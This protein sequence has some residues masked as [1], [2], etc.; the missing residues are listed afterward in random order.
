MYFD[1]SGDYYDKLAE[2]YEGYMAAM[3]P[4]RK[5]QL[6][7]HGNYS[8]VLQGIYAMK[9]GCSHSAGNCRL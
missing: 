8:G 7:F 2:F 4:E 9:S 3:D 1:T 5:W 6:R